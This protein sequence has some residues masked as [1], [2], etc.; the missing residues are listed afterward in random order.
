MID[1]TAAASVDEEVDVA[2]VQRRQIHLVEEPVLELFP[3]VGDVA[4][5]V[6]ER[7]G[8]RA[9]RLV[10]RRQLEA[11]SDKAADWR[12]LGVLVS[13]VE[14]PDIVDRARS[15]NDRGGEGAVGAE[16]RRCPC[17]DGALCQEQAEAVE[18]AGCCWF[19]DSHKGLAGRE[20]RSGRRGVA[21]DDTEGGEAAGWESA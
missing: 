14:G 6:V 17:G 9:Q 3:L 18:R 7:D 8:V 10:S 12:V 1:D 11:E 13:P 2:P 5:R 20:L 15:E 16:G 4:H 19:S 21:G